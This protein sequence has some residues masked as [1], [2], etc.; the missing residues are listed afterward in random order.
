LR[1]TEAAGANIIFFC[2]SPGKVKKS[3]QQQP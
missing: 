1:E 3:G 2:F